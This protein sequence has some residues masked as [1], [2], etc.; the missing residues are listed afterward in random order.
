M[1]RLR[2]EFG[3]ERVRDEETDMVDGRTGEST[4]QSCGMA[5]WIIEDIVDYLGV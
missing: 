2:A 3:E 5:F 4:S 1:R